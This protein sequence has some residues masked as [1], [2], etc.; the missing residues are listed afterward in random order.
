M[1]RI[2]VNNTTQLH[3]YDL[4]RFASGSVYRQQTQSAV[5]DLEPMTVGARYVTG[6]KWTRRMGGGGSTTGWVTSCW[7]GPL[8]YR[9]PGST[10]S[11]RGGHPL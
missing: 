5:L 11:V 6:Q 8:P 3:Q 2:A 4:H 7:C 1:Y 9:W 10:P